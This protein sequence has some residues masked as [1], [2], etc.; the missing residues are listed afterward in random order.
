MT[1]S[2]L[3]VVTGASRGIG[4]A[5]AA[6]LA[7]DGFELVALGSTLEGL[8]G[9]VREVEDEGGKIVACA[10]DLADR[11]QVDALCGALATEHGE[12]HALVNC[13]GIV[14]VAPFA[15]F[16]ITDWDE[17]VDVDLR[18]AF[19]ISRAVVP[20]LAAAAVCRPG[21]S[22]IVNVSSVMGLLATPGITSYA[23]AKGGINHLT[24]SMAVEL[25]DQGIRVNAVAPGF[26]K[27]D[28][29]ETSHPPQRQRALAVSHPIGRV[30]TPEEVAAV[31]SFLCSTA[32][33]FVSGAVIPV[34]GALTARIA[35]PR[36]DD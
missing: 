33:S 5:I 7:S 35:A 15:D 34:D 27:T 14:R 32:A 30:G 36:I 4:R 8:A 17:V 31:V 16:P 6:R 26:I 29:F 1:E 13:A 2:P 3:A 19:L 21:S 20:A 28:M 23:A 12:I 9:V 10:Y 11:E 18:A 25:G 22:S 24:R